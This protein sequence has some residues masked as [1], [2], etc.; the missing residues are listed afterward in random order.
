MSPI[1][2]NHKQASITLYSVVALNSGTKLEQTLNKREAAA[3]LADQLQI[4][5]GSPLFWFRGNFKTHPISHENFLKFVRIYREKT[6][7]ETPKQITALAIDLYG[8]EYKKAIELLDPE[9]REN[10]PEQVAPIRL[11]GTSDLTM[12][13]NYLLEFSSQE[14]IEIAFATLTAYQWSA[15]R[16]N[17]KNLL[18]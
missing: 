18:M 13:I 17:C 2:Q 16:S 15:G 14:K 6:G 4:H 5:H 12:T 1:E 10:D 9:D 11:T 3:V 7:L 8:R